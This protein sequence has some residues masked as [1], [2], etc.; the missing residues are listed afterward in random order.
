MRDAASAF[1]G[2]WDHFVQAAHAGAV[3]AAQAVGTVAQVGAQ[4]A[5]RPLEAIR[6]DN[7]CSY[8]PEPFECV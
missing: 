3:Q 6:E 5:E 8:C 7:D 2:G 4:S 1:R